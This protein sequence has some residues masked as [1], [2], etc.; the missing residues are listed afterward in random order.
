MTPTASKHAP[1]TPASQRAPRE[2]G[3]LI[4]AALFTAFYLVTS[5]I[6]AAHRQFWFDE[7]FTIHIARLP[8]VGA[9]WDSLA[10]ATDSIPPTYYMLVRLFGQM[11]G[12]SELA[13]RMPSVLAMTV[14]LWV[15][16]D[17]ARRLTSGVFGLI[18]LAVLGCSFLP[19][20]GYEARPYALYFMLSAMAFWL[21]TCTPANSKRG[22]LLFGLVMLLGVTAHY[23]AFMCLVPFG[24]WEVWRW[25]RG[26]GLSPKLIAGIIGVA[27]PFALL[28]R[29]ILS[30]SHQ[31]AGGFWNR[32][33]FQE[34]RDIF[35]QLFP[36]ALFLLTLIMLWAVLSGRMASDEKVEGMDSAESIGWLFLCIPLVG[37][38]LAEW[39]TNAY[40]SRYF[41]CVLPGVAV[42]FAC[43][44]WRNLRNVRVVAIGIFIL[45][46]AWGVVK[47][48]L[49]A[50]YPASVE[51]VGT[52]QF[53][54]VESTLRMDG[55]T[56]F[57]FSNP[58]LFLASQYYSAHPDQCVLLLEPDFTETNRHAGPDP[59]LHQR[60]EI[61]LARYSPLKIWSFDQ[62]QRNAHD[63]ALIAPSPE[64]LAAM[65][66][67]GYKVETRFNNPIPVDYLQ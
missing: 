30:F 26:Q 2:T 46:A 5:L 49:V 3:A 66:Q 38:A 9:L 17:C 13:A 64:G 35:P 22:A 54:E 62:F 10:H 20:Y 29:L 14:G 8:T 25:K 59:Y 63:M 40:F 52:R 12:P 56:Y 60:L 39:K 32:P 6:I 15:T 65:K 18:A 21:W 36:D 24:L 11:F 33:S 58:L 4:V 43:L 50:M 44:L 34:L 61:N 48:G 47:Q 67:A 19:Y 31:F 45:L 57:V 1:P 7:L 27:I 55:K 23:Y 51:A 16:F 28:S 37:F 41:I 42:A 53:L